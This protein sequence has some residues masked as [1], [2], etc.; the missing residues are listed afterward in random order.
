MNRVAILYKSLT[1]T[2]SR[3]RALAITA[4]V[5]LG[6]IFPV[7]LGIEL[8]RGIMSPGPRSVSD[9]LMDFDLQGFDLDSVIQEQGAVPRVFLPALP[10]DWRKLAKAVERKRAFTMIVLPLVLRAN[11]VLVLERD[12][13]RVISA[14]INAKEALSERDRTWILALA[15]FYKIDA[16][17]VTGKAVKALRQRVD[18]VPPSLAIAQ[19]A[20]ESGWGTSRFTTEGNALF[21]Q[22]SDDQ[23]GGM[24][25][26]GRDS[27]RTYAIQ[28][29]STLMGSIAAYMRN[30]NS[31]RAYRKFRAARAKIRSA[32][33]EVAGLPLAKLLGSY[34]QQGAKYVRALTSII[35]K[36]HF[37]K[38]D[39]A[40]L[41]PHTKERR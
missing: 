32:G 28:R 16:P 41:R 34:S 2:G 12:R 30:L 7:Y 17:Q 25:P 33:Q 11:E 26:V 6:G 24:I 21:G 14:Q 31:H 37:G 3:Y 9:V 20:I 29:F 36:N 35:E 23:D 39:R 22:W 5:F 8:T 10:R 38:L 19:A 15:E 27:G 13:L 40:V 1:W 4:L 18:I